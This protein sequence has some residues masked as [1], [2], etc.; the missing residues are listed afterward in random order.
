MDQV[1]LEKAA[2]SETRLAANDPNIKNFTS[3]MG[4]RPAM[5][6]FLAAYENA[7]RFPKNVAAHDFDML[8][9]YTRAMSGGK[10]TETQLHVLAGG[11]TAVEKFEKLFGNPTTGQLLAKDMRDQMLRNMLESYNSGA[12]FANQVINTVR[13]RILNKN[14]KA[15]EIDL[16]QPYLKL[17]LKK[18]VSAEI[19]ELALEGAKINKQKEAI[20][21]QNPK[22]DTSKLDKE[23]AAL[24]KEAEHKAKMLEDDKSK[25]SIINGDLYNSD[26]VPQGIIGGGGNLLLEPSDANN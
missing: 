24:Q 14:P 8:E 5:P 4:V 22:A 17:Y 12:G 26:T 3:A 13:Q 2:A 23:Y 10:P 15:S 6:K 11:G 9:Q 7:K 19:D 21:K 1:A 16:P 25:G 20:L 18:D